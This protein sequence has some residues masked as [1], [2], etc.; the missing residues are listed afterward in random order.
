MGIEIIVNE[1]PYLSRGQ[2]AAISRFVN[3]NCSYYYFLN[4]IRITS[5]NVADAIKLYY[6]DED[7]R[8]VLLKYILRLEIQM[9]KDLIKN[10]ESVAP[11]AVF[12]NDS[13]FYNM[14]F[15]TS[16][17]IQPSKFEITKNSILQKV[18]FMR[19]SG[20]VVGN[21][22]AFYC[23]DFG[24]FTT[25]YANMLQQYRNSFEHQYIYNTNNTKEEIV[26]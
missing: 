21:D 20:G 24:N 5:G 23:C 8:K 17:G 18:S 4:F 26:K 12:W 14:R 11:G 19:F 13:S 16:N 10:V 7:L 15:T 6:F 2:K 22:R 9:K 1:L 25:L 3:K